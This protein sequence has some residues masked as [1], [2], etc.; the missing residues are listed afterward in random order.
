MVFAQLQPNGE[1]R[2]SAWCRGAHAAASRALEGGSACER[3]SSRSRV[4]S[5]QASLRMTATTATLWGLP[6]A[7][8]HRER[9]WESDSQ[10][11]AERAARVLSGV[12]PVGGQ[13]QQP[14][15]VTA[16]ERPELGHVGAHVGSRETTAAGD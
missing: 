14:G 5:M 9:A 13:S 15:R 11:T 4:L 7:V 1:L 2:S 12:A 10:R 3:R 16:A 8:R 6:R